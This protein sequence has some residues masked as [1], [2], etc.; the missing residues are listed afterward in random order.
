MKR[1]V[2]VILSLLTAGVASAQRVQ[3][4][5]GEYTYYA[6]DNVSLE[7]AKQ[8]AIERAKVAAIAEEFGTNVS[9]TNT[10]TIVNGDDSSS[11]SFSSIGMT[12]VKGEWLANTKEPVIGIS[13]EDG[14]LVVTAKVE[15]KVREKV[16]A[17]YNLSIETLCNDTPSDV[18]RSNDRFAV[19]FRSAVRGNVAIFLIDDNVEQAYCLLPYETADG[20][21]RTVSNREEYMFLSTKD[22][23]Y[24]YAEETILTTDK[25]VDHNRLVIIF[26]TNQFYMP[27]TDRGEFLPELSVADFDKWL[28]KNRVR[29]EQM[30]VM[31]KVLEIKRR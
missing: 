2:L 4:I 14:M 30:T 27:L 12:E 29:D 10:S 24:P 13:Y 8:T 21:A 18:F 20:G 11:T 31:T 16:N 26:S 19:R 7:Q 17:E 3:T 6:P 23:E 5:S 15:G 9:Q 28:N 25:E 1:T 22:A